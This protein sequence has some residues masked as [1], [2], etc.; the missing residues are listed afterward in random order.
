MRGVLR[1]LVVACSALAILGSLGISS[2]LASSINGTVPEGPGDVYYCNDGVNGCAHLQDPHI[3]G[4]I[5]SSYAWTYTSYGNSE[6]LRVIQNYETHHWWGWTTDR[7]WDSG[8]HYTHVVDAYGAFTCS[9]ALYKFY[10]HHYVNGY[11]F[12]TLQGNQ[13]NC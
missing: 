3:N 10:S 13:F 7:S 6:N 9:G 8:T 2:A 5:A 11:E 1:R 12:V 4:S